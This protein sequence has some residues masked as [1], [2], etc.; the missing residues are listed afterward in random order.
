MARKMG[1]R[2]QQLALELGPALDEGAEQ[3]TVGIA[4][5]AE[6]RCRLVERAPGKGGFPVV[7]W[8]S[9]CGGR[10][11]QVQVESQ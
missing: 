4:V 2:S 7:Q 5:R 3:A 11:D 8:M 9:D 1:D 10:F 6:V